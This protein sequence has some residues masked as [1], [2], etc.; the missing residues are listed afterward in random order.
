MVSERGL[1]ASEVHPDVSTLVWKFCSRR[2][3]LSDRRP[4]SW[5]RLRIEAR[6]A[7]ARARPGLAVE[8]ALHAREEFQQLA[9][10]R[11][12]AEE[13]PR[14]LRVGYEACEITAAGHGPR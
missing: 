5:R 2:A 9:A 7:E 14:F 4:R 13:H 8:Q 3:A 12:N 10:W 6:S 11:R 1:E